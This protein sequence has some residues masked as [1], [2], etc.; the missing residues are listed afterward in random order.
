MTEK[1]AE[2]GPTAAVARPPGA[3]RTGFGPRLSWRFARRAPLT[4]ALFEALAAENPELRMERTARG[5]LEIMT[6]VSGDGSCKNGELVYEVFR[7]AHEQGRGLGKAFEATAGFVL[8]NGAIRSPD[9][10]W[11]PQARW[12]ALT[13]AQRKKFLPLCPDFVVELRS[14]TDRPDRLRAKMREYLE[15]G[16]RLGWLIDPLRGTVEIYRPGAAVEVL[17]RPEALS[18]EGVLPGLVVSLKDIL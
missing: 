3:G 8:P 16:A 6:P 11:I 14:R 18:G 15:Q 10:A 9:L 5:G 12:D 4:D 2:T 13:A 17:Q 7:W 1:R